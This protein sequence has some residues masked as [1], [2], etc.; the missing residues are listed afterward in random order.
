MSKLS[1]FV[2]DCRTED[3]DQA[4]A[5]WAAALGREL[6]P[7]DPAYERYRGFRVAPAEPLLLLQRVEHDSRIHLDIEASDVDAEVAR[8]R[9]LG[10]VEVERV[11][12]WVVMEAPTGHRFCVVRPQ[13]PLQEAPL[14]EGQPEH[15]AL[16]ALA[17]H[18]EGTTKTFLDPAAPPDTSED[19][20]FVE[21]MLGGR[22]TR[23]QW[24]GRCMGKPRSGELVL[25]YHVDEKRH[26]LSW[27]DTFHTGSAILLFEG[28]APAETL[29]RV[30]GGYAAGGER[31]GWRVELTVV[32]DVLRMRHT[33]IAPDG[34]EYPAIE[35]DWRRAPRAPSAD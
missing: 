30:T 33:N 8:L 18:Y 5:F 13:R 7:T 4:A 6:A 28:A 16:A 26:E 27:V 31:W 22:W 9:G 1:T 12:T 14:Y 17:G 11:R 15:A 20:L 34:T 10:A 23:V 32:G 24:F 25:G 29:L 3:L 21:P 35:T 2:I 19:T